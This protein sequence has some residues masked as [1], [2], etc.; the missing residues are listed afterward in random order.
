MSAAVQSKEVLAAPL[1]AVGD[2]AATAA[3][4]TPAAADATILMM[5]PVVAVVV[6]VS[7]VV[8]VPAAVPVVAVAAPVAAFWCGQAQ[9][10][11]CIEEQLVTP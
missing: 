9:L 10:V 3:A 8:A 4:G 11:V 5:S 6:A 2:E 1:A 7:V